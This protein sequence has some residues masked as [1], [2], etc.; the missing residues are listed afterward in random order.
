MHKVLD[1]ISSTGGNKRPM[2]CHLEDPFSEGLIVL[3]VTMEQ[4]PTPP[5]FFPSGTGNNQPKNWIFKTGGIC[6]TPKIICHL[7][8][9]LPGGL[10]WQV[11]ALPDLTLNV[12]PRGKDQPIPPAGPLVV[13]VT[14]EHL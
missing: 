8:T 7:L 1:L 5:H 11:P 2:P 13:T 6:Q 12:K 10:L 9:F 4:P 3:G 14:Q